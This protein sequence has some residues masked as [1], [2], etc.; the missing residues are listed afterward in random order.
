[1]ASRVLN[2]PS[3]DAL[4][5]FIRCFADGL[6]GRMT[7]YSN[8]RICLHAFI[9]PTWDSILQDCLAKSAHIYLNRMECITDNLRAVQAFR[10]YRS[11]SL[12]NE[13]PWQKI[14]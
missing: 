7:W 13:C 11:S 10:R 14:W 12:L 8:L 4:I 3:P 2:G 5:Y 9:W 6:K 1:M